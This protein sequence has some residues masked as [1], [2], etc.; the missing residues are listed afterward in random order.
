M[1]DNL[2]QLGK[3]NLH[4]GTVSHFKIDCDILTES[5][6]ATLAYIIKESCIFSEVIGV[7]DGGLELASKLKKYRKKKAN[8]VLIVDDVLT[9]GASMEIVRNKLMVPSRG[10]VVFARG[11]CPSWV[12]PIFQMD[13]YMNLQSCEDSDP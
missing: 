10:I 7:P 4:S 6:W 1:A 8:L 5:D 2:F 11:Q 13:T 9:T 3:F 12:I